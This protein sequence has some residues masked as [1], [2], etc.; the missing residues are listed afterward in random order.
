M[1]EP[2]TPLDSGVKHYTHGLEKATYA[3]AQNFRLMFKLNAIPGVHP[4]ACSLMELH[5]YSETLGTPVLQH[6]LAVSLDYMPLLA[7]VWP[8]ATLKEARAVQHQTALSA[9]RTS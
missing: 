1:L 2:R 7:S 3:S 6:T 4:A 5:E 8:E 9:G